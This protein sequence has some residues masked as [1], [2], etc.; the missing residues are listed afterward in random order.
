MSDGATHVAYVFGWRQ[1]LTGQLSAGVLHA[2]NLRLNTEVNL[3][4]PPWL[5]KSRD[6]SSLHSQVICV[7]VLFQTALKLLV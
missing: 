3:V 1:V 5:L 7:P 2:S 4:L 6:P